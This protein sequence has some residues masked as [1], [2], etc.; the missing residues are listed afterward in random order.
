MT[1]PV[2]GLTIVENLEGGIINFDER[3]KSDA[4]PLHQS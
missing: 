3:V 1:D 2:H 4:W